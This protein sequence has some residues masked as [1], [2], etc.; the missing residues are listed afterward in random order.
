LIPA[1]ATQLVADLKKNHSDVAGHVVGTIVIDEHHR[2][3]GQLLAQTRELFASN[4]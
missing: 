4:R 1:A 3:E 2:T